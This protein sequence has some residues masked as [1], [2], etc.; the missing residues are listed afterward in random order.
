MSIIT[1]DSTQEMFT[2]ADGCTFSAEK[3]PL[4]EGF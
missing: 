2:L 3:E 4:A 1:R